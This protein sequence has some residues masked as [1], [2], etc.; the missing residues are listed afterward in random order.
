MFGKDVCIPTLANSLQPKCRYLGDESY[1]LSL[2]VLRQGCMLAAVNSKR[3][4]DRQP[5]WQKFLKFKV[6]DLVLLRNHK[7]ETS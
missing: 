3:A 7:K 6:G 5:E 4:W 1:L 2:E